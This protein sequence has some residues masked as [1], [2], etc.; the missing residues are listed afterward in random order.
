MKKFLLGIL[1]G[2]VI[3]GVALVVLM[4]A[5]VRW[6]AQAPSV[7]A[8]GILAVNLSGEM[9]EGLAEVPPIPALARQ[10]PLAMV[11]WWSVLR[12]AGKDAR[13]KGLL[14][15]PRHVS[16]GVSGTFAPRATASPKRNSPR[17]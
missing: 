11:E 14:L 3:A 10:A 12:A 2:I 6:S 13:V 4:F 15:R 17:R 5:A 1:A 9:P 8:S 16:A 7:P